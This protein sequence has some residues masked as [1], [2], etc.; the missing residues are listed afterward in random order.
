MQTLTYSQAAAAAVCFSNLASLTGA[1][2]AHTRTHTYTHS[3]SALSPLPVQQLPAAQ[4]YS[5]CPSRLLM[6]EAEQPVL[7]QHLQSTL[8]RGACYDTHNILVH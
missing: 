3:C 4:I 7:K 1:A 5:L 2:C 6:H 8:P